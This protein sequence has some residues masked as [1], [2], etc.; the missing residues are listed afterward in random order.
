MERMGSVERRRRRNWVR[1]ERRRLMGD[2]E[3]KVV[4]MS[5]VRRMR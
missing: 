3:R 5:M 1:S 2:G 4:K